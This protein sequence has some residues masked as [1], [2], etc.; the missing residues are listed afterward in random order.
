[1]NPCNPIYVLQPFN[2]TQAY[3]LRISNGKEEQILTQPFNVHLSAIP[4]R[5]F[6][7]HFKGYSYLH[8][9]QYMGIYFNIQR[10][11][12]YGVPYA[13]GEP[14]QIKFEPLNYTDHELTSAIN[15]SCHDLRIRSGE[16]GTIKI[17]S[18]QNIQNCRYFLW[19]YPPHGSNKLVLHTKGCSTSNCDLPKVKVTITSISGISQSFLA[20]GYH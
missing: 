19:D 3:N 17:H 5:W 20:P 4:D 8:Y 10:G 6:T 1:M 13:G 7:L 15:D 14:F 12:C 18:Y 9:N 11:T 2:T 16:T